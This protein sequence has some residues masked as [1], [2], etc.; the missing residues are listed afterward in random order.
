MYVYSMRCRI[1]IDN[2]QGTKRQ[3]DVVIVHQQK[4]HASTDKQSEY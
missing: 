2:Q 1:G 4:C 3:T